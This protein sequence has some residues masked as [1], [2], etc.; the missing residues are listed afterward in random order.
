MAG[1]ATLAAGNR[2]GTG[3]EQNEAGEVAPVDGQSFELLGRHD[4]A[5]RCFL[6]L[7]NGCRTGHFDGVGDGAE[8]EV[9]VDFEDGTHLKV[10]VFANLGFEA[11]CLHLQRVATRV[12]RRNSVLSRSVG[13]DGARGTG[14]GTRDGDGSVGDDVAG[15]VIDIADQGG[16]G[17]RKYGCGR[18]R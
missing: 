5:D 1:T 3:H 8:G 11:V 16:G 18:K 15:R 13:L 4:V 9:E 7:Q 10:N 12:E 6:G 2:T 14:T 17:L